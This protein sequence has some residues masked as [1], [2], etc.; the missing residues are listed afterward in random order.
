MGLIGV[1]TAVLTIV[2]QNY[3][4]YSQ[5][6]A[7]VIMHKMLETEFWFFAPNQFYGGP[8]LKFS[9]FRPFLEVFGPSL[10]GIS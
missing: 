4:L 8:K 3:E 9:D 7:F 6:Y 5:N 10:G 1:V 2:L